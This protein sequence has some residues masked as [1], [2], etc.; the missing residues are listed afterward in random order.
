M[1]RFLRIQ[2]EMLHV[3]VDCRRLIVRTPQECNGLPPISEAGKYMIAIG[4][5][6]LR[7][8]V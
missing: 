8:P 7:A 1:H 4:D 2:D 6:F 3:I 5:M